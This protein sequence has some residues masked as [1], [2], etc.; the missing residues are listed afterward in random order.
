MF[1]A[2]IS[3]CCGLWWHYGLE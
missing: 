3:S 1:L 2:Y